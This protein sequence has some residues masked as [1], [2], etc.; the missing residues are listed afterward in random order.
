MLKNTMVIVTVLVLVFSFSISAY[1]QA[2]KD[3]NLTGSLMNLGNYRINYIRVSED[4]ALVDS[5]FLN[6]INNKP[7]QKEPTDFV[8][9]P[10][11]KMGVG[12]LNT[13]TSWVDI[14]KAV[15]DTSEKYNI[16]AGMTL[17]LGK[18]LIDGVARGASGI[19]DMA[20]FGLYPYD[21]PLMQPEFKSDN[22][23]KDLRIT[24]L[25]W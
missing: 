8:G 22:T 10:A 11:N 25:K 1:A 19:Y 6:F 7:I 15:G 21:Q 4:P 5:S 18:G 9:D 2:G 17:G 16:V 13:A 23:N 12:M 3:A 20:T 24:I 14:P